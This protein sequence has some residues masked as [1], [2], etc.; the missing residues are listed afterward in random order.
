MKKVKITFPEVFARV[1]D[2]R[3][4]ALTQV[5]TIKWADVL[6]IPKECRETVLRCLMR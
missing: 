1:Y 3:H 4:G 2:V 5:R 6:A